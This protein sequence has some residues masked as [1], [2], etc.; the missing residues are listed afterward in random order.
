MRPG[1]ERQGRLEMIAAMALSGTIGFFVVESGQS[2]WN[3]VF[4]RCLFG[5]LSLF[6][7]CWAKGLLLPWR[8]TTRTLGLAVLSGVIIRAPR[9]RAQIALCFSAAIQIRHDSPLDNQESVPLP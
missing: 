7:Y 2:V 1:S 8:F 3:V 4:F 6:A 9:E 5:A